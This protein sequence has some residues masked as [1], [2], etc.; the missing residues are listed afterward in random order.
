MFF[1]N[2]LEFDETHEHHNLKITIG[3]ASQFEEI[4][5]SSISLSIIGFEDLIR[6][7]MVTFLDDILSETMR[8]KL[9]TRLKIVTQIN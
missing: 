5:V 6:Y 2:V 9:S 8:E 4:G 1:A 3:E 7:I